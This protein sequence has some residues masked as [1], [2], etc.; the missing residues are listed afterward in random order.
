MLK[1]KDSLYH[2][3][4]LLCRCSI[5]WTTYSQRNYTNWDNYLKAL[6]A[7]LPSGLDE[8]HWERLSE[9]GEVLEGDWQNYTI[10]NEDYWNVY[11][12]F[13]Q[14]LNMF[15]QGLGW[16]SQSSFVYELKWVFIWGIFKHIIKGSIDW[17]KTRKNY[18][19]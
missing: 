1:P 3:D 16:W 19:S 6:I 8:L 13:Y 17:L 10:K 4:I 18:N 14:N 7:I 11:T 9:Q 12:T 5:W 2:W 15:K